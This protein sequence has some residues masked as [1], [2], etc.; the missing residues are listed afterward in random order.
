MSR[1][2]LLKQLIETRFRGSQTAFAKAIKRSPAQVNQWIS[3]HRALGDAGA[4]TIELALHLP[5]GYFDQPLTYARRGALMAMELTEPGDETVIA[6][7]VA[8]MR[9]TDERG[10]LLVLGA[11]RAVLADHWTRDKG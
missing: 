2:L 3:G 4:R 7:V 1:A 10:R 8:L 9:A 5:P 11:A 6:E